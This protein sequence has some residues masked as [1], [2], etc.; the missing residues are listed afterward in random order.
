MKSNLC[1]YASCSSARE[2]VGGP[3]LR[4]LRDRRHGK[5]LRVACDGQISW[6]A[7]GHL[8]GVGTG[9]AG[10]VKRFQMPSLDWGRCRQLQR[11]VHDVR[12]PEDK[13]GRCRVVRRDSTQHLRT[14]GHGHGHG[15]EHGQGHGHGTGR[16]MG[17]GMGMSMGMG[18]V[19]EHF[20]QPD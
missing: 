2:G 17:M 14:H 7:S 13:E 20:A 12:C 3:D 1:M 6:V 8:S 15:H 19:A 4:P 11:R 5:A 10:L 18:I 16:G 9:L